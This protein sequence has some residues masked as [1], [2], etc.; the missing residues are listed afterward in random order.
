[1]D[2]KSVAALP[3]QLSAPV[4]PRVPT[5]D[6]AEATCPRTAVTALHIN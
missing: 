3:S 2:G 4:S 6:S 1:M 5:A